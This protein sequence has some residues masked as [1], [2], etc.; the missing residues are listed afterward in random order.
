[1]EANENEMKSTLWGA[2]KAIVT[3]NYIAHCKSGLSQ[4]AR[5]F[6]NVQPKLT[7]KGATKRAANKAQSQQKNGNNKY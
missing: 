2:A 3:E 7:P 5:K 6:S 4:E 1:M